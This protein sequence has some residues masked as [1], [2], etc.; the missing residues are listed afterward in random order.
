VSHEEQVSLE[1]QLSLKEELSLEKQ[2]R[3][4]VDKTQ[5]DTITQRERLEETQRDTERDKDRLE[6]TERDRKRDRLRTYLEH[7]TWRG[8][9]RETGLRTYLEHQTCCSSNIIGFKRNKCTELCFLTET[10]ISCHGIGA[11][12]TLHIQIHTRAYLG[13]KC[14]SGLILTPKMLCTGCSFSHQCELL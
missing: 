1:E 2:V 5:T 14:N 4:N 3:K 7:Q 12:I 13:F 11:L 6:E 10:N 8:T 9:E